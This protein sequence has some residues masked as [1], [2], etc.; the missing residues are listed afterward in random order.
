MIAAIP[1]ILWFLHSL[2]FNLIV[3]IS[4]TQK[5][6]RLVQ[7]ITFFLDSATD[8]IFPTLLYLSQENLGFQSCLKVSSMYYGNSPLNTSIYIVK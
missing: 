1:F 8:I 2:F 3:N 7:Q 6:E 4:E 5:A